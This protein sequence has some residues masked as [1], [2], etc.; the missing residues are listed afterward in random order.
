[1]TVLV[2]FSQII[3]CLVAHDLLDPGQDPRN[4]MLMYS[5]E[6]L[7]ERFL[8]QIL[9]YQMIFHQE[10]DVLIYERIVGTIDQLLNLL[11]QLIK[12]RE[13]KIPFFHVGNPFNIRN[14]ILDPYKASSIH[15]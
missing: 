9:R 13:E 3:H 8:D 4:F 14:A 12:L 6:D 7:E 15:G 2:N 5:G 10:V 11:I 1:M